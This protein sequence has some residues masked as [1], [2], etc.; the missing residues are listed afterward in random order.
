[1]FINFNRSSFFSGLALYQAL[2]L[3]RF[4]QE[5]AFRQASPKARFFSGLACRQA[6]VLTFLQ[7]LQ[8]PSFLLRVA[9]VALYCRT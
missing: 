9:C 7:A 4:F 5:L 2:V 3:A 8:V 6:L 1:L